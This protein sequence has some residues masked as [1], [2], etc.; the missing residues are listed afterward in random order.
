MGS[1]FEVRVLSAHNLGLASTPT[2]E[3]FGEVTSPHEAGSEEPWTIWSARW[4]EGLSQ[5]LSQTD[6]FEAT[7]PDQWFA[8]RGHD[9]SWILSLGEIAS[10][11]DSGLIR[12]P[13]M[14]VTESG[15]LMDADSYTEEGR[16]G[17]RLLPGCL[18][19]RMLNSLNSAG[20][21]IALQSLD[22]YSLAVRRLVQDVALD[23]SSKVCATAF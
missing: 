14:K 17:H 5:V 7:W 19:I 3:F 11:I 9:Y 4:G 22:R 1:E 10:W 16:F 6:R 12:S 20:S 2:G 21:T 18:D 13:A 8:E 23:L 15:Q